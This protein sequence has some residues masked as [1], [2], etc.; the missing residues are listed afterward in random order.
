VSGLTS[1][2]HSRLNSNDQSRLNRWQ[3]EEGF[4]PCVDAPTVNQGGIRGGTAWAIYVEPW[5]SG[6]RFPADL[7]F[8]RALF[9]LRIS[10]DRGSS[11]NGDSPRSCCPGEPDRSNQMRIFAS[12]LCRIEPAF[13]PWTEEDDGLTPPV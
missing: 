2:G 10:G 9:T 8:R 11:N 3:H 6:C 12:L 7:V 1:P 4:G 13:G 5:G